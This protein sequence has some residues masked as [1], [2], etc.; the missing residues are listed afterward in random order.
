MY[1]ILDADQKKLGA[2]NVLRI[3]SGIFMTKNW[4]Q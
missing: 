3:M 4:D 2:Q 1:K